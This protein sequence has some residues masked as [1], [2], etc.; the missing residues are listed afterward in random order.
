MPALDVR[1]VTKVYGDRV[2]VDDVSFGVERGEIFGLL[3]PNGAGK[4]SLL[5]MVMDILRPDSGGIRVLDGAGLRDRVAYLPEER[6]LYQRRRVVDVLRYFGE[7]KGLATDLA[8]RRAREWLDRLGLLPSATRR[9]RELSKG[10]QQKVQLAAILMTGPEL[11]VLDEPFEGLDPVNRVAVVDLVQDAAAR[12]AAVVLSSHR[13]DQ[14]EALCRRVLL[15]DRGREVLSGGVRELRERFA[16]P[17]VLLEADR[18]P[19]GLA[20]ALHVEPRGA[21]WKIRL[22]EG[23]TPES[24]L[25]GALAAGLR[26][27]RFERALPTLDEIFVRAV[28]R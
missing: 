1:G 14:V 6:G 3:G 13:M 17:A 23:A 25:S 26:V 12:G 20:G 24:F 7:L 19:S 11:M 2:A 28:R 22:Q 10:M 8:E 18:D 15:L 9:M 4:S 5:R 21:G 16:E 27:A